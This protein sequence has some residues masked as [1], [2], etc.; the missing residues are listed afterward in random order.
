MAFIPFSYRREDGSSLCAH[1]FETMGRD[2][3]KWKQKLLLKER[4][5]SFIKTKF[6]ARVIGTLHADEQGSIPSTFVLALNW[7]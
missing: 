4:D 1:K 6:R 3:A 7:V 5:V 2:T